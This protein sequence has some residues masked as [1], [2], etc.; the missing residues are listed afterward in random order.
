MSDL[1]HD[2][3]VYG[4]ISGPESNIPLEMGASEV[5]KD[6][7]GRFVT[8]DT[9]GRGEI[10]AATSAYIYGFVNLA[11]QTTSS[12][13][14]GTKTTV[15]TSCESIFRIPVNS[16]TYANTMKG[17]TCDLS[18]ASSVQGAALDASTRDLVIIVGGDA[19][20]NNYVDVKM[21]PAKQ[22]KAGV[23]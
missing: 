17:K 1:R 9:N 6:Q 12:T 11:E 10:S 18:V 22:I 13:E 19:T 16:G 7:S 8:L 3:L 15:N 20:N 21:V 5:I 14:G 2:Q 4:H 23:V